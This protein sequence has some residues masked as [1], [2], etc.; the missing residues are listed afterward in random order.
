MKRLDSAGTFE[1]GALWRISDPPATRHPFAGNGCLQFG[2]SPREPLGRVLRAVLAESS[3]RDHRHRLVGPQQHLQ[4]TQNP[5]SPAQ[6]TKRRRLWPEC[7]GRA[8]KPIG[9]S[10]V[11]SGWNGRCNREPAV[12]TQESRH[13]P[14]SSHPSIEDPGPRFNPR[15]GSLGGGIKC[16]APHKKLGVTTLAASYNGILWSN[17]FC[18]LGGFALCY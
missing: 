14:D 18:R 2:S 15:R 1:K 13:W 7:G 11:R 12:G 4:T 16:H 3:C 17:R 10:A 5:R 9:T 8:V 6:Q